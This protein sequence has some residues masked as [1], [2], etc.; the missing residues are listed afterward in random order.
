[1][2]SE[3]I[4]VRSNIALEAKVGILQE[5][6]GMEETRATDRELMEGSP[7]TGRGCMWA[8]EEIGDNRGDGLGALALAAD[9]ADEGGEAG[10]DTGKASPGPGV[11]LQLEEDVQNHVF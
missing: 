6:A 8:R 1:M 3:V 10:A 5:D 4:L 7:T 2:N 9:V 11:V